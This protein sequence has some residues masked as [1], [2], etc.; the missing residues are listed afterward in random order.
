MLSKLRG[1]N[2]R[3]LRGA[4]PDRDEGDETGAELTAEIVEAFS[5]G[6][7]VAAHAESRPLAPLFSAA[8]LVLPPEVRVDHR[9]MK[10]D[11]YWVEVRSAYYF[12]KDEFPVAAE[13]IISIEDDVADP[14]R[15]TRPIRLFPSRTDIDLFRLDVEGSIGL[16]ANFSIAAAGN[17]PVAAFEANAKIGGK[18]ALVVGPIHF[19][20][21][22]AAI[23][24]GG[25]GDHQVVWKY[26]MQS[27]LAG[28]NE[29]V[30]VLVLKV[31]RE[32]NEVRLGVH[33]GLTPCRHR[34]LLFRDVLPSLAA[35]RV[36]PVELVVA[37]N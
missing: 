33:F 31:A 9:R 11:F 15:R 23:E 6:V 13:L 2:P 14:V 12:E 10:Y 29:L 5:R 35:E 20:L 30:S 7:R 19:Q 8:G 24:V 37:L 28:S 27:E 34:W 22:K 18:A 1:G 16:D 17:L 26:R 21:R 3:L 4:G 25:T 36:L 32:A